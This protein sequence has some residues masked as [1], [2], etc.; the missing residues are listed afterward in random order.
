MSP[1]SHQL[2]ALPKEALDQLNDIRDKYNRLVNV[3]SPEANEEVKKLEDI[4]QKFNSYREIKSLLSKFKMMLKMEVSENR[5]EKQLASLI[6]LY[7]GRVELEEALK[8]KLGLPYDKNPPV[9]PSILELQKLDNEISKIQEELN[10]KEIKIPA[11]KRTMEERFGPMQTNT[12]KH[13]V[14]LKLA[15]TIRNLSKVRKIELVILILYQADTDRQCLHHLKMAGLF[16]FV[17]D[18]LSHEKRRHKPLFG[19]QSIFQ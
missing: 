7:K 11:G 3:D 1:H 4:V 6:S 14:L 9:F 5:K 10:A 13:Y 17:S 8:E 12:F 15:K 2:K 18:R 16:P 19:Y